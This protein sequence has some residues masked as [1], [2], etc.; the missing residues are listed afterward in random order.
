MT[1]EI[2]VDDDGVIGQCA[3]IVEKFLGQPMANLFR[4]LEKLGPGLEVKEMIE[5]TLDDLIAFRNE[6]QLRGED[7]SEAAAVKTWTLLAVV[8]RHIVRITDG[9]LQLTPAVQTECVANLEAVDGWLKEH[10]G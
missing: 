1:V 4:W 10:G 3:P 6:L 5:M 9:A 7:I 8:N 2:H